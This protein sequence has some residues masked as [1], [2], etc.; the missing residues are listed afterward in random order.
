MKFLPAILA[1]LL[2]WLNGCS[3]YAHNPPDGPQSRQPASSSAAPATAIIA[4]V[5]EPVA[6]SV[7]GRVI[8]VLVALCDNKYQGIVPVPARIGNGD[9]PANNLYWGAAYGVK[10]FLTRSREWQLISQI[11]DVSATVLE[12]AVFRHSTKDVWLIADAYRGREIKQTIQ[13]L[14]AYAAGAKSASV[15]FTS[16]SGKVTLGG[17]GNANLIAFVGHNGLMDFSLSGY[18]ARQNNRQHDVMVL[19]C[20]SKNYFAEPLKAAGALPLLLTT[21]LM[22]PEAYVLKAALDGWLNNESSARIR[23]R[24]ASAYHQYQRCGLK[25]ARNLFTTEP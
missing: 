16:A 25:A 6:I 7:T 9:D 2:M 10:T 11:S 3:N 12:R 14:F 17:G 5:P 24:A 21:G 4:P 18:P 23:E 22:A 8:H 1:T 20:I 19:C 13:D 15:T